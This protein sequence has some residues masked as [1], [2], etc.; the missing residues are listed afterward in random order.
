MSLFGRDRLRNRKK[1]KDAL[2]NLIGKDHSPHRTGT[3]FCIRKKASMTV[4]AAIVLPLFVGFMAFLMFYFCM[5][6][7]QIGI[8][9]AMAYTARTTAAAVKESSKEVNP[10]K[11]QTLLYAQIKK[12][13]IPTEYIDGGIIGISLSDADYDN[14]DISLRVSY[15]MTVPIGFFGRRTYPVKQEVTARKWIGRIKDSEIVT[16]EGYVYVTKTGKAYHQRKDC[17]YLDLSIQS[18]TVSAVEQMRNKNG[19]KYKPCSTCY[20]KNQ[21]TCYITDYGGYYHSR[22]D[23]HG[24]KR[25][26]YMIPLREVGNRHKCGKC[27]GG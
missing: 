18:V 13:E 15:R 12:E 5:M 11:V 20:K 14:A 10:V 25:T 23:C 17:A 6:R 27:S 8:E 1:I 3:Y 22:I 16:E 21:E 19:G 2:S 7:V 26:V 9:Q 24:L 4:E